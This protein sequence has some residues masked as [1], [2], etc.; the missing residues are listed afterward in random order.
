VRFCEPELFDH[1]AIK[2]RLDLEAI[3][4][5]FVDTELDQTVSATLRTRL[6]AFVEQLS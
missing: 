3:P 6:E 5:L 2:Q 1:P 4:V